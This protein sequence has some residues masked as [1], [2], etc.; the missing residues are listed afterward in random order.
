MTGEIRAVGRLGLCRHRL[1][2]C[3]LTIFALGLLFI[4]ANAAAVSWIPAVDLSTPS[5]P[6]P[7]EQRPEVAM[8][9][10]GGAVAV[11][12]QSED[13]ENVQAASMTPAGIWEAPVDLAPT[14][15]TQRAPQVAMNGAGEAVAV[16]E[17]FGAQATVVAAIRA[18][19][20]QWG[21]PETLSP[22]GSV[23]TDIDV[24]VGPA[25]EA[26]AVWSENPRF[27][28]TRGYRIEG[29]FRPAGGHWEAPAT[30]S[31][32]GYESWSPQVAISPTGQIVATWFGY[33][34]GNNE[35]TVQVADSQ[36]GGWSQP[37]N[38]SIGYSAWFP[39]VEASAAGATVIWESEGG[40]IEAASRAA[41]G[42]WSKPVEL[43]GPE[44]TEPQIGADSAGSAVAIWSSG[45]G[46]EGEYIESSTLPVGGSWS[47]PIEISGPVFVERTEPRLAVAPNGETL[48]TWSTWRKGERWVE[49]ASGMEGGW[50]DPTPLSPGGTW[51]VR[52]TAAL[53]GHG[54]G[55]VAWW[56]A[57]PKLPQA[58]EFVTPRP[59]APSA[60]GEVAPPRGSSP[61][62]SSNEK[63]HSKSRATVRRVALVRKGKVFVELRCPGTHAC[64]G[65]LR[66][67]V[68]TADFSDAVPVSVGAVH[69]TIAAGGD[70]TVVTALNKKG[71]QLFSEAGTKGIRVMI[72]GK[73]LERRSLSLRR[74]PERSPSR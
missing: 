3:L 33:Y 16:W 5:E 35:T 42:K 15:Q 40:W 59:I 74:A 1:G 62:L 38:L 37:H 36:G 12:S 4:P 28:S 53:D 26:V 32:A 58:T 31:A 24:A 41:G 69:F 61:N 47:E 39:K 20:G 52:A 50:E 71:R 21:P 17:Q 49:T 51:A 7:I 54:D 25:G 65:D 67:V 45:F 48:A 44:S 23:F 60:A 29:A 27:A 72:V 63:H 8:G 22:E 73:D 70:K 68:P 64:E 46:E 43:S 66:L 2:G 6:F 57:D 19:S 14:V 34:S 18:P 10:A 55:V 11:W 9:A 56:A 13:F 30:I